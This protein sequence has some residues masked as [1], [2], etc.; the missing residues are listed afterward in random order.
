MT[1]GSVFARF[2]AIALVV[3][4]AA[5]LPAAARLPDDSGHVAVSVVL[6]PIPVIPPPAAGDNEPQLGAPAQPPAPG[7]VQSLDV[8]VGPAETTLQPSILRAIN[9]VRAA[10]GLRMLKRSPLLSRAAVAH[11]RALALAGDF[12]HEWP[13]GRPFGLWILRY[14][15]LGV[16]T[17]W[18]SGENLLWT[19]GALTAPSAIRMWLASPEHRRNMLDPHWREIGVGVVHAIAAG[20]AFTGYDIDLAATEFGTRS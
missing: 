13:D 18:S 9:K 6:T 5:P 4:V 7:N 19:S 16:H 2:G 12:Q 14:Y 8:R 3:G 11:A 10:R 1:S 17:S 15:P 20:G